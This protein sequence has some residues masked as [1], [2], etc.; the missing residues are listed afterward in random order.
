[1]MTGKRI[2]PQTTHGLRLIMAAVV[3]VS[4]ALW[5]DLTHR[6]KPILERSTQI[7]LDPAVDLPSVIWIDTQTAVAK[8][9]DDLPCIVDT[10]ANTVRLLPRVPIAPVW[11]DITTAKRSL[12]KRGDISPDKKAVLWKVSSGVVRIPL[13]GGMARQVVTYPKP[14]LTRNKRLRHWGAYPGSGGYPGG[15]LP[16]ASSPAAPTIPIPEPDYVKSVL[17]LRD[18]RRWLSIDS[19]GTGPY[20]LRLRD[21][22]GHIVSQFNLPG[23]GPHQYW[24]LLGMLPGNRALLRAGEKSFLVVDIDRGLT[25]QEVF[26]VTPPPDCYVP[27]PSLDRRRLLWEGG[28]EPERYTWLDSLRSRLNPSRYEKEHGYA[29]TVVLAVSDFDGKNAR[30][31]CREKPGFDGPYA[32]QWTTDNKHITFVMNK[33]LWKLPVP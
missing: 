18:S 5:Q 33:K 12:Y 14:W 6:Y 15:A 23:S 20:L 16:P 28:I 30:E 26:A 4:I 24:E 2:S 3:V 22:D 27:I 10:S 19:S 9:G 25:A 32:V 29:F 1:M 11:D 13:N 7:K 31:L 17:W 21:F 8:C